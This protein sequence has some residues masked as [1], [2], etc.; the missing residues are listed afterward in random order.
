VC[1]DGSSERVRSLLKRKAVPRNQEIRRHL[2]CDRSSG[3]TEGRRRRALHCSS[4]AFS[5][6]FLACF[7]CLPQ[8]LICVRLLSWY[9]AECESSQPPLLRSTLHPRQGQPRP[10]LHTPI[11]CL[12]WRLHTPSSTS[13]PT[14]TRHHTSISSH[15]APQFPTSTTPPPDPLASSSSTQTMTTPNPRIT[16]AAP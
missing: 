1:A 15:P 7:H 12:T 9:A 5:P 16:E 8:S 13:T 10:P 11:H 14:C 4:L 6:Y 2:Q 3:I